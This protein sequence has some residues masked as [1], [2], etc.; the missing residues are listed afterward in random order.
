MKKRNVLLCAVVL[1]SFLVVL[2]SGC[3]KKVKKN[4]NG[5]YK[6]DNIEIRIYAISD[7]NV[8]YIIERD[9]KMFNF[10]SLVS[11]N[12]SYSFDSLPESLTFTMN[13][14]VI[15]L[16]SDYDRLPSGSYKRIG[17]YSIDLFYKTYYGREKY[18]NSDYQGHFTNE[19]NFI[20]I[21]QPEAQ[22]VVFDGTIGAS[23]Y[24][25]TMYKSD[26]EE[27]SCLLDD[28]EIIISLN[29]KD[30]KLMVYEG[31]YRSVNATFKKSKNFTKADIVELFD[32]YYQKL[33]SDLD[34]LIY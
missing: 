12:T 32:M 19:E 3:Q 30:V 14:S 20:N 5:T 7:D 9:G 24:N 15:N 23:S 16:K 13:S 8:R 1:L 11:N 6:K 25:C 10:G 26:K 29:D 2:S 17:N 33:D 21:Y 18:Y 4:F 34:S 28:N 31:T 27:Y 22:V